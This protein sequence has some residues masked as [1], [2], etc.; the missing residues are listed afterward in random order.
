MTPDGEP[1]YPLD[2]AAV[3]HVFDGGWMWVLRFNNGITSAGVALTDRLA[4]AFQAE[5]G[6]P[7]W[8]RILAS[9][10]SV[11]DQFRGARA[12]RPFVHAPRLAFQEPGDLWATVGAPAVGC[13]RD[14]P[15]AVHRLPAD[16]PGYRAPARCAGEHLGR[17]A[18]GGGPARV[19]AGDARRT[20]CDRTTGR[21]AVTRTWPMPP[22]FKRLALLY[23]AAASYAETAWRLGRRDLA[24]GFLLHAHPR[25]GPELRECSGMACQ[26]LDGVARSELFARIDRAIEPFDVAGLLDRSRR[27]WYPVLAEDLVT[28]ASKLDASLKRW[29]VCWNDADSSLGRQVADRSSPSV[30]KV[31]QSLRRDHVPQTPQ[32]PRLS[33]RPQDS[34]N[35]R[36]P[37]ISGTR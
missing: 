13:R 7:A 25:F 33:K 16:A 22:L 10:P 36:N 14:R 15:A 30:R 3:H 17:T 35:D 20:G 6:A 4:A 31:R 12:M 28:N 2:D 24:P 34:L 27:D 23:F 32:R 11:R 26:P 5:E 1:P 18:A 37:P 9:L 8:Q 19:R 21:G 29:N